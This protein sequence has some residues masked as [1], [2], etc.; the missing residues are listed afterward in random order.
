MESV[1][2][3]DRDRF[4]LTLAKGSAR[5]VEYWVDRRNHFIAEAHRSGYGN[6]EIARET[7][8]SHT[9]IAKILARRA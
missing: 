8:L 1:M 5:K 2:T 9:A 4:A 3:A 6:R 7:G